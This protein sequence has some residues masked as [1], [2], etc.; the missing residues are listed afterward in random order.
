M[1]ACILRY[2]HSNFERNI[3]GHSLLSCAPTSR[4]IDGTAHLHA[5]REVFTT[6]THA[7]QVLMSLLKAT[8]ADIAAFHTELV[9]L[10]S[11][12]DQRTLIKKFLVASGAPAFSS[13]TSNHIDPG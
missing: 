1:Y 5:C 10:N 11:E 9:A 13:A 6:S 2:L 4:K 3:F 7:W 8:P 12:K